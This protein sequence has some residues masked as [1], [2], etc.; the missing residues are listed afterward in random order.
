MV[1]RLET[2]SPVGTPLFWQRG[3]VL[4]PFPSDSLLR[5]I[6][7]LVDGEAA[8]ITYTFRT[9]N[10]YA[11]PDVEQQFVY[12]VTRCFA[13]PN[14][15]TPNGDATNDS[16]GPALFG[17]ATQILQ[18]DIYSRWGEKVFSAE[19]A[20][21]Q[22]RWNGTLAGGR[23]A[24]SDVYVYLLKVRYPDGREEAFRGEVTLLR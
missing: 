19:D 12:V 7:R 1:L 11:C 22:T 23:E 24:P 5:E 8:T 6:P 20:N 9:A 4:L 16:F 17:T 13:L 14:A 3:D 10:P 2:L 21:G 15:F 18:F